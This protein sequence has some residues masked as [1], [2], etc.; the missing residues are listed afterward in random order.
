MDH[1]PADPVPALA[2]TRPGG[3]EGITVGRTETGSRWRCVCSGT[4][5]SRWCDGRQG[6]AAVVT[7]VAARA[8]IKAGKV[9]LVGIDP[10][11]GMELGKPRTCST[12]SCST[13]ARMPWPLPKPRQ[14][15]KGVLPVPGMA[16][17]LVP[18]PVTVHAAGR[19][20]SFGGRH[21]SSRTSSC[22]S[23]AARRYRRS[24]VRAGS[25]CVQLGLLGPRK[26]V[27][28]SATVPH[29]G[30][31]RGWNKTAQVDMVLGTVSAKGRQRSRVSEH[32][33]RCLG[34]GTASGNRSGLAAFHSLTQPAVLEAHVTGR[35]ARLPVPAQPRQVRRHERAYLV[36][37]DVRDR[38]AREDAPTGC[39]RRHKGCG[40]AARGCVR[41]FTMEVEDPDAYECGRR[42]AMRV[43]GRVVW[44][45]CARKAQALRQTQ[46]REGG[47]WSRA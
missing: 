41:P 7:R 29:E 33:R 2:E 42:G 24:R 45:P 35:R 46:C 26:E 8:C 36:P 23:R 11:G 4:T 37:E 15:R 16:A 43:D 10:K 19:R 3:P 31:D 32:T 38:P 13:T 22:G 14:G 47:T 1:C 5:C 30:R 17:E 40:G 21:A 27:V 12:V 20:T 9:R 39:A 25:G 18:R 6:I 44:L 34:E 28:S